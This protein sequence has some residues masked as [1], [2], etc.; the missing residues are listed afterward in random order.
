M[1]RHAKETA[2]ALD[3]GAKSAQLPLFEDKPLDDVV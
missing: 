1:A 2:L 3:G